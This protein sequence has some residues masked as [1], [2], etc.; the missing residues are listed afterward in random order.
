MTQTPALLKVENLSKSFHHKGNLI[1]VIKSLSFEIYAKERIAIVGSSGA[2]KSTLLHL[3]GALDRPT[4]G[5][6]YFQDQALSS[7]S[8]DQLADFRNREIGFMFQFHHLLKELT[9]LENVMMPGLICRESHQF[10]QKKATE[11][12][13][14]VGLSH[15]LTHKP[16]ELSGGEQ[17]RVALARALMNNPKLLLADEPTGNLDHK[18]S[19]EIHLLLE[20]LNADIGI[21]LLVVTHNPE[22]AKMMPRQLRMRDGQLI[23]EERTSAI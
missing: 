8:E 14:Q 22:L 1:E 15:R 13:G 7:R 17:Q 12:L 19:E 2:G 5:E 16:S 6:I 4:S 20:K 21:T 3:L 23:N 11:L 9:A 10:C 18:T